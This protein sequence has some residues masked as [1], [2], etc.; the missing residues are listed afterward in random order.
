M[1]RHEDLH[2][3]RYGA[4]GQVQQNV[5]NEAPTVGQV[6]KDRYRQVHAGDDYPKRIHGLHQRLILIKPRKKII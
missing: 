3:V 1:Q 5:V 4:D 2:G 6:S